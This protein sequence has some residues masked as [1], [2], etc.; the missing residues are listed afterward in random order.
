MNEINKF[1]DKYRI[2]S[3]RAA[4]HA[5]DGGIYFVTICTAGRL[6]QFGEI[7]DMR[8]RL[9]DIGRVAYDN[10]ANVTAHYPYA[11]IPLFTVMPNHIHAI[12]AIDGDQY[13][14]SLPT[15]ETMCTSS[16]QQQQ[17]RWKTGVVNEKMRGIS[18][19]RGALSV[20]I[21]GLKRAV[22]CYAHDNGID[23][24]WQPRF[25]DRIIRHQDEMNRISDYIENN[26]A[27][28]DLDELNTND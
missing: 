1:Q 12:V 9:S 24:A 2:P 7:T 4:W 27:K 8:M 5:Y 23:F 25:Y 20:V 21:S 22:T 3:A 11:E 6:H 26:V 10:F 15:V 13:K 18:H 14:L 16:L 28:W 19:K 17:R